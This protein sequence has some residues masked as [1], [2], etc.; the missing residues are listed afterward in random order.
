VPTIFRF[1][2]LFNYNFT[3]TMRGLQKVLIILAIV[4]GSAA[5]ARADEL[6]VKTNVL[7][8]ATLSVSLGAEM[9]VAPKWSV[10]LTGSYNGWDVGGNKWRHWILQP[11]GRYWLKGDMTGHFFAANFLFGQANV[12]CFSFDL[13]GEEL[14]NSRFQGWVTGA[15]AGYGYAWRLS[16]RWK[17]ELELTVGVVH[18]KGD[19]YSAYSGYKVQRDKTFTTVAPTK[20]AVT[21]SYVF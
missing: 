4:I 14:Q 7:Y 10:E 8:D 21:F 18:F 12:G 9:Q 2:Q 15:G 11:E 19:R 3:D 1:R 16:D 20:A 5:G 17:L 13:L 6:S